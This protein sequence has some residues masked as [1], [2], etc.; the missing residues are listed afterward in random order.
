MLSY[1]HVGR[2]E[3]STL[4]PNV[5]PR[6]SPLD[7]CVWSPPRLS[8]PVSS[9]SSFACMS[10]LVLSSS[11]TRFCFLE[12][13]SSRPVSSSSSF[14]CMFVLILSSCCTRF[15]FLE[16]MSSSQAFSSC[17]VFSH[18]LASSFCVSDL[19][20]VLA[21]WFVR[22]GVDSFSLCAV[23]GSSLLDVMSC[24][25]LHLFS[26]APLQR[27]VSLSVSRLRAVATS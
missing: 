22:T 20:A 12:L 27:A 16:L 18:H 4:P 3:T 11:C 24:Y 14:A 7:A 21:F 15:Y 6:L 5:Q 1:G 17:S 8:R 9:S 23:G 25:S 26:V 2:Y 10:V 19:S 13:S